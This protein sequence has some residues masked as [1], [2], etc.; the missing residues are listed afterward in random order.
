MAGFDVTADAYAQFMGRYSEPLA[1]QFADLLAPREGQRALDVGC[2]TGALTAVLVER[3]GRENVSAVD[4]SPSFVAA[5]GERLPGVDIRQGSAD[6]LTWPDGSFDVTAASLVV[7]FMSDP[8]AG[9]REMA[10]V[11]TEGGTIGATVWDHAGS[12]RGALSLFWR[13][14]KGLDPGAYDESGMP[15]AR[16]GHL[17]EL[18][19]DAGVRVLDDTTITVTSHYDSHQDWWIP[20]TLGVG[21]AGGYVAQLSEERRE[22]LRQRCFELLPAAPFEVSAVAWTVIGTRRSTGTIG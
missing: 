21:P 12:G 22:A 18:F 11:T 3:L 13:A 19:V 14:V 10:R 17:A 4:P 8:V 2:G 20:Y 6:A 5:L 15:G 9:L 7:H 16:A 1:V